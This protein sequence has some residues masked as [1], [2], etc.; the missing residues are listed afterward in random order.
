[1]IACAI[2]Y[3]LATQSAPSVAGFVP[4]ACRLCRLFLLEVWVR[5]ARGGERRRAFLV[6]AAA[7][8]AMAA[9]ATRLSTPP[10]API[11]K[12]RRPNAA[13][14]A[15]HLLCS[16]VMQQKGAVFSVL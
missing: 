2:T 11:A 13:L 14:G 15:C 9:Q 6:P 3:L 1:L 16:R 10:A 7:L 8:A 5:G 12:R 4:F